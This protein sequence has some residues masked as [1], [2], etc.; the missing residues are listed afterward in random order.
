[1]R[2]SPLR[3]SIML[4]T[5]NGEKVREFQTLA[6]KHPHIQLLRLQEGIEDPVESALTFEENAILKARYYANATGHV[7]LA[8]DSGITIQALNGQPGIFT[9]RFVDEKGGQLA[10]FQWL[11]KELREKDPDAAMVCALALAWPDGRVHVVT[12]TVQGRL[13]FPARGTGFGF[14][15]IFVPKGAQKTFAEDVDVKMHISHRAKAF[16]QLMRECLPRH[17]TR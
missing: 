8:D 14:D 11:E 6:Q 3:L 15:P 5:G 13:T 17:E 4:G 12:D 1:M 9:K 7:T 16:H 2:D 10:T